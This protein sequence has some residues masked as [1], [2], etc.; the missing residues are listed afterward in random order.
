VSKGLGGKLAGSRRH[1]PLLTLPLLPPLCGPWVGLVCWLCRAFW[2]GMAPK[3]S[4]RCRA[5]AI[6]QAHGPIRHG[7][8]PS[9]SRPW[10]GQA[11]AMPGQLA[12]LAI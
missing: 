5:W 2:V 4:L 6:A 1:L 7:S 11:H 10:F 9:S 8:R 12:C 3:N